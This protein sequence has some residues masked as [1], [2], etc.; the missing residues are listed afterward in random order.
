MEKIGLSSVERKSLLQL[1]AILTEF[2]QKKCEYE[3]ILQYNTIFT[4]N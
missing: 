3:T 4:N 1:F 2:L